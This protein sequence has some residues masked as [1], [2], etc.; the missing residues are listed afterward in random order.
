M[1]NLTFYRLFHQICLALKIK[2]LI[3]V[4]LTLTRR[5]RIQKD[6]EVHYISEK[7]VSASVSGDDHLIKKRVFEDVL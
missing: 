2:G 4:Y 5:K 1:G 6:Q 3:D 7:L